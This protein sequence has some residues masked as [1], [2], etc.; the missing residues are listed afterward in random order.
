LNQFEDW[1][2]IKWEI[3]IILNE[4]WRDSETWRKTATKQKKQNAI[5]FVV[6]S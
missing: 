5:E 3:F 4:V 2:E 6:D 1:H